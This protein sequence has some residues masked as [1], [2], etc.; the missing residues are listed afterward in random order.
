[1]SLYINQ[2]LMTF[3]YQAALELNPKA[4]VKGHMVLLNF[5]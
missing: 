4:A 1:M 5:L 2:T 3:A